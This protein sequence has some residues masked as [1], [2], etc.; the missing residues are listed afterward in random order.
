MKKE[1]AP[2]VTRYA[3][4]AAIAAPLKFVFVSDLHGCPNGPVIG[5][6]KEAE[7]DAVL[8]GGDFV[9]RPGKAEAGFEFLRLAAEI[10][11]VF[12]AV[13][14]HEKRSRIDLSRV[15]ECGAV[16]LDNASVVFR[17]IAIGGLSSDREG[18]D[19]AFLRSFSAEERFRLL[20]CHHPEY[21]E[22]YI[23][24]TGI[25]LTVSGHVHGGQ[26]R[27]FGRGVFAPGQGLFPRYTG[28]V[29][30]GGRLVVGRGLG[31]SHPGI[32]RINNPPE[33]VVIDLYPSEKG[34][35]AI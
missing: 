25:D 26:W 28:G 19:T 35:A 32:V 20:V 24:G 5:A 8:V 13:G 16:L 11:P 34:A 15:G 2:G 23:R 12:V 9:D 22:R 7:P 1:K 17:D 10:R 27:F 21:Y 18:P 33:V 14:N 30:D 3:L 31:D 6:I 29:Y 4:G